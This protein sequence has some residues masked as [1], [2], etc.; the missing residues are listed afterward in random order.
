MAVTLSRSSYNE[1]MA[2]LQC[3][4]AR[5]LQLTITILTAEYEKARACEKL[6][7]QAQEAEGGRIEISPCG[8][9]WAIDECRDALWSIST[10]M[11]ALGSRIDEEA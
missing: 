10:A 2:G 9:M 11:T 4:R 6:Y 1:G 5:M 3:A 8:A 7:E